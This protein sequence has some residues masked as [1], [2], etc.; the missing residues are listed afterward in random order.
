MSDERQK[1]RSSSEADQQAAAWVMRQDRGLT[2]AEQDDFLQWL[3]QDPTHGRCYARHRRNWDRLDGL[4]AWRPRYSIRPNPDLLEP[5]RRHSLARLMAWV[6]PL[7][8]AVVLAFLSG[9]SRDPAEA[10]FAIERSTRAP[11]ALAD[12]SSVELNRDAALSIQFTAGERRVVLERGEAIFFVAKDPS[13]PFIVSAGGVELRAVGTAFNVKLAAQTVEVLVTEGRVAVAGSREAATPSDR[14]GAGDPPHLE[15]RQRAVIS[16]GAAAAPPRVDTL[17]SGEVQRV[18]AWQHR[19]L[20]FTE[21]PLS[22]IVAEFNRR[23]VVTLVI[24]DPAIASLPISASFRSDNIEGFVRLLDA[25]FGIRAEYPDD[26][27]IL[28]SRRP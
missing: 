7:A 2:A 24:A 23:N 17:T 25:G 5:A 27:R 28:L 9:N 14:A 10:P 22:S 12:G 19:L 4:Q 16:L 8:A 6:L 20:D 26:F 15:A 21:A 1:P 18:L 3:A 13:R 11:Q